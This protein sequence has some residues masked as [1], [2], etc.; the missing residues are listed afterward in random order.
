MKEICNI[1]KITP[2][3]IEIYFCNIQHEKTMTQHQL[4]LLATWSIIPQHS[5]TT[6]ATFKNSICNIRDLI[7]QHCNIE[8]YFCNNH[9]KHLQHFFETS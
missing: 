9:V 7:L 3:S 8:I 5:E 1:Q 4:M 2:A 6:S